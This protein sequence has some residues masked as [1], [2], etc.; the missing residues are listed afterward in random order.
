MAF[1]RSQ[2]VIEVP[3]SVVDIE[4]NK[5][6]EKLDKLGKD[7]DVA[8][9]YL[10]KLK[11]DIKLSDSEVTR[12]HSVKQE[13][14]VLIVQ[15]KNAKDSLKSFLDHSERLQEDLKLELKSLHLEIA[16]TTNSLRILKTEHS[17]LLSTKQ[18]DFNR[19]NAEILN[20][21]IKISN[22]KNEE[23]ECKRQLIKIETE[24]NTKLT[25]LS[26]IENKCNIL[27]EHSKKL[28]IKSEDLIE[29][30]KQLETAKNDLQ[31]TKID[32][33]IAKEELT[34]TNIA[35]ANNKEKFEKEKEVIQNQLDYERA[36][37]DEKIHWL[38]DKT[39]LLRT[40][41]QELEKHFGRKL[42]SIII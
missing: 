22:L 3:K 42:N 25:E 23:V 29:I 19:L 37:L 34:Q 41:K 12:I 36:E 27:I 6:Y 31:Q 9:K 35:I 39:K 20:L 24:V 11:S 8:A 30:M 14:N 28:E 13:L 4:I 16:N 40:A 18:S 1:K 10:L 21:D 26:T 38:E 7:I 15:L 2:H 5:K 33:S 32:L 17:T